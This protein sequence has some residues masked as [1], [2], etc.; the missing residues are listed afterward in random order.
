MTDRALGNTLLNLLVSAAEI[1]SFMIYRL[2]G[3]TALSRSVQDQ[4][5]M[6]LILSNFE[7]SD[8]ENASE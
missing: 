7:K 4:V 3:T 6:N 8:R 5:R 1:V 2:S